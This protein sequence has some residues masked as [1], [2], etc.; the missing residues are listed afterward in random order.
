MD[1]IIGGCSRLGRGT[2]DLWKV[3]FMREPRREE[4]PGPR[5]EWEIVHGVGIFE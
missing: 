4:S 1:R 5:A 3:C 2:Y